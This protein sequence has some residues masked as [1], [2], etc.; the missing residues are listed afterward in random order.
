M[1]E[2]SMDFKDIAS[3]KIKK[4]NWKKFKKT[5]K[6]SIKKYHL[7]NADVIEEEA[8]AL[9]S[10]IS[11]AFKRST[12]VLSEKKQSNY[13]MNDD[14]RQQKAEVIKFETQMVA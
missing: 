10:A 13:W 1:I 4:T 2:F 12:S 14:L 5:L 7:W 11:L 3:P 9:E 8:A 6:M